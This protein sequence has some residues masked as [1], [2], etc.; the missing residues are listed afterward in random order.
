MS[1]FFSPYDRDS[2]F[3]ETGLGLA[4]LLSVGLHIVL[5][6]MF[7]VVFPTLMTSKRDRIE[8][9]VVVQLLG[10]MVPAAPAAP[11]DLPVNPDLKGP[12]VVEMPKTESAPVPQP[13]FTPAPPEVTAPADVIPLG[14]K[15]PDK[16][17]EIK[18]TKA[19]PPKVTAPKVE[20][21]KPPK[22]AVNNDAA[23]NARL[24][25]LER[26]VEADKDQE[27]LDS[28]FADLNKKYGQGTGEGSESGGVT[29]GQ[30]IDP[31]KASY[32]AHIK[33]LISEN[34]RPPNGSVERNLIADYQL[35]I[36]PD[37]W[38]TAGRFHK[39]SGNADFDETVTRAIN[40]SLPFPPLP[41][42]FEGRAETLRVGF[43]PKEQRRRQRQ[44]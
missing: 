35:T 1:H 15:A 30:R 14:P 33:D 10:S 16:P 39:S 19:A 40:M 5:A 24:K 29:G 38:I 13:Q 36:Q 22:T 27:Y 7:L 6:W 2:N 17:P 34:W 37:G 23:I 4:V 11:A 25:A 9:V 8:D 28:R 3:L 32:Y 26:K 21:P 18:K 44:Q 31:R 41:E 12:D 43:D 20:P 42:V